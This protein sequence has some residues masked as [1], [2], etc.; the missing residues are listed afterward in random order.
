MYNYK[1]TRINIHNHKICVLFRE[2]TK[3][4]LSKGRMNSVCSLLKS[5]MKLKN[6]IDSFNEI[7]V[8]K[9][10]DKSKN[11]RVSF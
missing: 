4:S 6:V 11:R 7:N 5:Y 1:S 8:S 3:R 9:S 10:R 2:H